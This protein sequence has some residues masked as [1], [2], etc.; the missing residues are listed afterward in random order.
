[1]KLP[2]PKSSGYIPTPAGQHLAV[3]TRFI[4]LG[5]QT[6]QTQFGT[7]VQHKVALA[8]E[9]PGHRIEWEKDGT[10]YEGPVL[11]YE[12]FTFS[13]HEKANFRQ[14]L[15]MWRGRPFAESDFGDGP[16]AFDVKNLIGVGAFLQISHKNEGG[17]VYANLQ[18]IMLPPGGKAAWPKPEGPTMYL[19]LNKEEFDPDVFA[20]LSEKMRTTIAASPEYKAIFGDEGRAAESESGFGERNPPSVT[21]DDEIPF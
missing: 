21:Y 2:D 15:E 20:S 8:W 10:K 17:T 5:T 1:M 11:H 16:D 4:D 14:K 3:C 12:R 13:T 9:I 18:A 19:A 6:T 7:K